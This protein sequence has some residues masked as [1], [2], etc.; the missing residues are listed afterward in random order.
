MQSIKRNL[1]ILIQIRDVPGASVTNKTEEN[2]VSDI[3]DKFKK[4]EYSFQAGQYISVYNPEK[5]KEESYEVHQVE[6]Y[7]N[8]LGI[9]TDAFETVLLECPGRKSEKPGCF[10]VFTPKSEKPKNDT[11]VPAREVRY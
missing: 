11:S 10:D 6:G 4:G 7:G 8:C 9:T 2:P 3:L 5:S 1:H